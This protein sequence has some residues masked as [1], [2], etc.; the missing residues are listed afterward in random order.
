[1]LMKQLVFR[2]GYSEVP[3]ERRACAGLARTVRPIGLPRR[4]QDPVPT[5]T[6][7][8]DDLCRMRCSKR[9]CPAAN[10]VLDGDSNDTGDRRSDR[11]A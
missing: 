3:F 5:T 8:A 1:M 4:A 9:A 6:S 11:P 2:K 7:F 10:R